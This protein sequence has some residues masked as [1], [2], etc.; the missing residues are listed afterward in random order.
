MTLNKK[1]SE[2]DSK[3]FSE[4]KMLETMKLKLTPQY[5]ES[6]LIEALTSNITFHLGNK[7]PLY[8]DTTPKFRIP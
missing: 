2:V 8:M 6:A 1:K 5:L 4:I 3:Y 7:I